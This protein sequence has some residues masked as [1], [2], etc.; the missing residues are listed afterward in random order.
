M[1]AQDF[2]SESKGHGEPDTKGGAVHDMPTKNIAA[3]DAFPTLPM[4][5]TITAVEYILCNTFTCT[6]SPKGDT[7]HES[8]NIKNCW[9]PLLYHHGKL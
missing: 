6:L 5:A 9:F 1:E 2:G 7:I 8:G 4:N 3:F